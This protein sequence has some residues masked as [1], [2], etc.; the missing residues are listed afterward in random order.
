MRNNK[1]HPEYRNIKVT[2][3][4]RGKTRIF[5][6]SGW[7]PAQPVDTFNNMIM[8]ASDILDNK[9]SQKECNMLQINKVNVITDNVH[10]LDLAIDKGYDTQ[11]GKDNRKS[12][13]MEFVD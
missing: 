3:F 10:E 2:D 4:A 5:T 1:N 6:E 8:E 12:I 13:M 9:M 7:I 11:W